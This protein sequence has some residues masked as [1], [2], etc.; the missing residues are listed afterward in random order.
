M[1]DHHDNF[2]IVLNKEASTS[3]I[4]SAF[5]FQEL[6]DYSLLNGVEGVF[7][8][9]RQSAKVNRGFTS[10]MS[11]GGRANNGVPCP[12]LKQGS[13]DDV[14]VTSHLVASQLVADLAPPWLG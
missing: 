8:S 9:Q 12:A 4:T 5:P 10:S 6:Q 13:L 3:V 7:Q 1:E 11:M 2:F 14:V